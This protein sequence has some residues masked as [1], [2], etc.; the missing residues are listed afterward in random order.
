MSLRATAAPAGEGELL[1]EL[2]D[3]AVAGRLEDVRR[4]RS[5]GVNINALGHCTRHHCFEPR[6][7]PLMWASRLGHLDVVK[8]L[9]EEGADID[10][11]FSGDNL[12]Q[13]SL[14]I[15][16]HNGRIDVV[17]HLVANG[18]RLDLKDPRG[19]TALDAARH[20]IPE[21]AGDRGPLVVAV[22]EEAAQMSAEQRRQK[23]GG[24]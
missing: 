9:V 15:A 14:H 8:Y 10:A 19:Q 7:T 18:A 20:C 16:S 6:F 21:L 5:Q 4:L 2:L 22:L 17:K 11:A 13:S 24:V 1:G 23:W 12:G 3:A